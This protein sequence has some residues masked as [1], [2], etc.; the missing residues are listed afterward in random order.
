VRATNSD[1]CFAIVADDGQDNVW[2]DGNAGLPLRF[3]FA[4][5]AEAKAFVDGFL[6]AKGSELE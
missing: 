2:L 3:K 5:V 4:T 1:P 6:T